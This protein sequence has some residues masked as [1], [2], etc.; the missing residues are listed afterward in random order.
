MSD[1]VIKA[2]AREVIER[3]AWEIVP[4]L[5]ESIVRAHLDKLLKDQGR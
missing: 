1:D 4:E 3:I 5:A 2:V